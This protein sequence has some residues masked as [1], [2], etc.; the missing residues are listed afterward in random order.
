MFHGQQGQLDLSLALAGKVA[1]K[2]TYLFRWFFDEKGSLGV[3]RKREK[4]D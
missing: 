2:I 1:E 4:G 3:V